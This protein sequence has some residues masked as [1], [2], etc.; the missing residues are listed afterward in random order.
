MF[1]GSFEEQVGI[2]A[3]RKIWILYFGWDAVDSI[4]TTDFELQSADAE[5]AVTINSP[6]SLKPVQEV[7]EC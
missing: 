1:S 4:C 6:S 7:S 5:C 2:M 3:R